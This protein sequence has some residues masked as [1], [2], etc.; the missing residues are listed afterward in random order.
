MTWSTVTEAIAE[1]AQPFFD[2]GSPLVSGGGGVVDAK[3]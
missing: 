2:G 3:F 1:A